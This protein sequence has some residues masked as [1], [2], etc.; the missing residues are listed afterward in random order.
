MFMQNRLQ[1][2]ISLVQKTGDRLVVFDSVKSCDPYVIMSLDEYENLIISRSGIKDLTE[3]EL[4]DKINR[5]I[6]VWKSDQNLEKECSKEEV[7][8]TDKES[9]INEEREIFSNRIEDEN[10]S[11]DKISAK[12]SQWSISSEIKE[13]AEEILDEDR[14]YLEEISF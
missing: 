9:N 1:K 2:A 6:A 7:E 5:D 14:Q 12:N 10:S 13:K 4:L 11:K 8:Y 3:D